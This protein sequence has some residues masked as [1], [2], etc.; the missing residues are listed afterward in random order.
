MVFTIDHCKM[1]PFTNDNAQKQVLIYDNISQ[2]F[3]KFNKV[4]WT[5]YILPQKL[6]YKGK[7]NEFSLSNGIMCMYFSLCNP[8]HSVN[9]IL[10]NNMLYYWYSLSIVQCH[11]EWIAQTIKLIFKMHTIFKNCQHYFMIVMILAIL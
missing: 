8:L 5:R 9:M 11:P 6:H 7:Q 2:Y 3:L 1:T 10:L 4:P